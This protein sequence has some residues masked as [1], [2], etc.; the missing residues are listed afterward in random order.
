M[1]IEAIE[2][3]AFG[4]IK[5]KKIELPLCNGLYSILFE[6]KTVREIAKQLFGRHR[7]C[8]FHFIDFDQLWIRVC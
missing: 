4:G 8:F 5:N 1:K 2:I 3:V 6:G 7:S